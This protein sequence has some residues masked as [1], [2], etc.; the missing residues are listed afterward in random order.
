M[1]TGM[2]TFVRGVIASATRDGSRLYVRGSISTNMG[3]APSRAMQA[4]V[5]KN[6]N[7]VVITSSPALTSSAIKASSKASE[8]DAQPIA[9]FVWQYSAIELSSR[10][11]S[12]LR[13]KRC[14]LMTRS[15]ACCNSSRMETYCACR[16]NKGT[17]IESGKNDC[18]KKAQ[19]AQKFFLK[20]FVLF[21]PLCG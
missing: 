17:F 20:H 5:A 16:S 1:W 2:M 19:K 13:T 3:R 15:T 14:E 8:P 6:E 10:R 4:A 12:S 9:C 21:V 7:G 11:P 18:H